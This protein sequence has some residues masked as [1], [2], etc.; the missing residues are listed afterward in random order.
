MPKRKDWASLNVAPSSV[1]LPS[2]NPDLLTAKERAIR[3]AVQN[4]NSITTFGAIAKEIGFSRS[5]VSIKM[6]AR[7]KHDPAAMWRIGDDWRIPRKTAG[8]FIR[9]FFG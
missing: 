5:Y 8:I 6:R 3:D 2:T 1:V 7:F 4:L 9:E